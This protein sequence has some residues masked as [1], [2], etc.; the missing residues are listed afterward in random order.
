MAGRTIAIPARGG[1]EHFPGYLAE[2]VSGDAP[3]VVVLQEIFGVNADMRRVC[4]WLAAQGYSALC[5]DL[6]WRLEP[7]VELDHDDAQERKKAFT[8]LKAF[9]VDTGVK[10]IAAALDCLRH[11]PSPDRR[12]PI[13]AVGYC[14][15]GLLAYLTA[16]RTN[17]DACV[18]Y[19]GVG[20]DRHLEEAH[21]ISGRLM[22]HIAE[23]D[24]FVDKTAQQ[25]IQE[26]LAPHPKVTLHD[27]PG[28]GHAFARP[29]GDSYDESAAKTADER[30][31][32]FLARHLR[33]S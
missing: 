25:H 19:Y 23:A 26:V 12:R 9:D 13:G 32:A 31:A 8:L 27:Y 11:T 14:L 4:D 17:A 33:A 21:A 18:G 24:E 29:G 2:P 22:L 10:D 30:T 6:F 7:G 16:C 3:G 1:Q 20:I 15:G 28:A 5:P